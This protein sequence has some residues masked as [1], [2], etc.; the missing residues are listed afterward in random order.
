MNNVVDISTYSNTC[1]YKWKKLSKGTGT[2]GAEF[3]MLA[4][5]SA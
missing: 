1:T 5:F 2:G 4:T 3:H